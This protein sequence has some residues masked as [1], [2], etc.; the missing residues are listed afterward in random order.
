MTVLFVLQAKAQIK[1]VSTH[2]NYLNELYNPAFYGIDEQYKFALNY[3]NQWAKLEGAPQT[4]NFLSSF[5]LPKINS[6]IGLN[7]SNDRIGALRNTTLQLGYNY[8][9][10]IKQ[11]LKIGIGAQAGFEFS[12][13]DASKLITPDGNY[14]GTINN[15]DDIL[16]NQRVKTFRP[17][18]NIGVSFN[19]K[20]IDAG[21]AYLNAIDNPSKFDGNIKNLETTYRSV[22]QTNFRSDVKT[23]ENFSL[24]PA[25]IIN[26]DFINIQTDRQL[27]ATYKSMVGF[28][29]NIR[30]YNKNAFESVSII[31]K[32]NPFKNKM[33][34][35]IYSYDFV[36][37]QLGS[38]NKGTHEITLY[39]NMKHKNI[40]IRQP[41]FINNPR[42]L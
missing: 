9:I 41:K 24:Q 22:L 3:R 10:N 30:G 12:N 25:L 33:I 36:F 18:L 19:T 7:I 37:K 21:I 20:Y 15:N 40:T 5:Y 8:I 4:F 6:G 26:T 11:K 17:L 31:G 34:G 35:C 16:A 29:T 23:G 39:Y 28:G 27:I 13:L 32:V 1:P 14:N 42:F 2:F 38:V